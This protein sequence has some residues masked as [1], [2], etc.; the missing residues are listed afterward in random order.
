[1]ALTFFVIQ[2]F[3]E[4][5]HQVSVSTD[6]LYIFRL[7]LAFL[8]V[9]LID[10]LLSTYLILWFLVFSVLLIPG[11]VAHRIDLKIRQLLGPHVNHLWSVVEP[12]ANKG[13]T[14]IEPH[15]KQLEPHILPVLEN[16]RTRTMQ[17]AGFS[18]QTNTSPKSPPPVQSVPP[19]TKKRETLTTPEPKPFHSSS[20]FE[21]FVE[22][23]RD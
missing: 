21:D 12:T 15:W 20:S 10:T 9:A 22:I 18:T 5:K 11:A 19:L 8:G 1:V 7:C 6:Y 23:S 16:I 2:T 14:S 17:L 3:E 13:W 4:I